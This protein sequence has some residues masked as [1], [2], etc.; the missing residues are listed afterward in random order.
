MP[1]NACSSP[2]GANIAF[3]TVCLLV[4]VVFSADGDMDGKVSQPL[5]LSPSCQVCLS[6]ASS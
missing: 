3:Y 6:C 2:V 4:V 1:L 5:R